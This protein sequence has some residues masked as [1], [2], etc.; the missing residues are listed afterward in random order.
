MKS[1]ELQKRNSSGVW[2]DKIKIFVG[3]IWTSA[4]LTIPKYPNA[5]KQFRF[6]SHNADA[7]LHAVA[8]HKVTWNR[9]AFF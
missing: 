2:Q 1:F 8:K 9:V 3:Q 7:Q 4:R 5:V 6:K